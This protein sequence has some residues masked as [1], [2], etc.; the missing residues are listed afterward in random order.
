MEEKELLELIAIFIFVG[1]FAYLVFFKLTL[2][3]S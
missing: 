2:L 1:I 3:W